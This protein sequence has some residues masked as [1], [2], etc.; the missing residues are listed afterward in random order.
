MI[1]SFRYEILNTNDNKPPNF[2]KNNGID[3]NLLHQ[4]QEVFGY[5][6]KT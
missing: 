3:D 5:L 2:T 4:L 6:E 1:P